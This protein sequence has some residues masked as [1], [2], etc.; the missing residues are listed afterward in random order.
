MPWADKQW[1]AVKEKI[2]ISRKT[3]IVLPKT[4][5]FPKRK[6]GGYTIYTVYISQKKFSVETLG[7]WDISISINIKNTT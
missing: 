7:V 4:T 5:L 1:Q 6:Y 2:L 3:F